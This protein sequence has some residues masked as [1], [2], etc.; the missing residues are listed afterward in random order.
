MTGFGFG[1]SPTRQQ[2]ARNATRPWT[3]AD[4]GAKL[5]AWWDAED[6]DSLTLSGAQISGWRDKVTDTVLAQPV[7]GSHPVLQATGFNGRPAAY[8]DGIDDFVEIGSVFLPSGANTCEVC[9]LCDTPTAISDAAADRTGFSYG[10]VNSVSRRLLHRVVSGG[11]SSFRPTTGFVGPSVEGFEGPQLAVV[12]VTG[13]DTFAKIAPGDESSFAVV[14]NTA[15]DRT[16]IGSNSTT[17][18]NRY[19][20]GPINTIVVTSELTSGE[21]DL[22]ETYLQERL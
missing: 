9:V 15:T 17:I 16:R 1:F 14:P 18:P 5:L 19:W 21:R 22:L 8:F 20:L 6:A 10:N 11:I 12:R 4:L 2:I 13:T 7:G 3:P